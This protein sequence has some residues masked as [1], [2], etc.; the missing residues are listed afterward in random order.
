[1]LSAQRFY[2]VRMGAAVHLAPVDLEMISVVVR[3]YPFPFSC[4]QR[5]INND[6]TD[7]WV[8]AM[9]PQNVARTQKETLLVR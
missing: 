7:A 5:D 1:M 3:C 9:L 6:K 4:A 2:R 8:P